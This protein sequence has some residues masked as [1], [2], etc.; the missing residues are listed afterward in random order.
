MYM[1]VP[2]IA[3]AIRAPKGPVAVANRP[4][5]LKIPAP[6]VEPMT[7]A[8]SEE[9]GSFSELAVGGSR[10]APSFFSPSLAAAQKAA[11]AVCA[12]SS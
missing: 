4:E 12:R 2:A 7:I 9:S 8:V 5:R 6:T 3:H 1:P 11:A 10:C